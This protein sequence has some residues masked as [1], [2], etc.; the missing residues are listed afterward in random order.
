MRLARRR[1]NRN[2]LAS[3]WCL[4]LPLLAAPG[5]A[6]PPSTGTTPPN[7]IVILMDDLDAQFGSLQIMTAVQRDLAKRGTTFSQAYVPI[8]LCCPSRASILTGQYPHNHGIYTNDGALG[9]FDQ[10]RRRGHEEATVATRLQ[11][12]GYRTA[13]FGK[14]LNGYPDSADKTYIPPGWSEWVSPAADDAYGHFHYTLNDNGRLV[15]YGGRPKDYLTDVLAAKADDFVRRNAGSPYFLYLSLYAP[16]RPATPAPRHAN[17]FPA[18]KALRTASFDEAD[19]SDKPIYVRELPRLSASDLAFVDDLARKRLQSL[20]AVDELIG[21][22]VRTLRT[23]KQL[24]N[25]YLI[26]TS[27]NGF[28]LGQ[29]RLVV[30]KYTAYEEDIRVPMVVRGPGV[31]AGRTLSEPVL[32]LDLVP[33]LLQLA[34]VQ[35]PA[36]AL[37]GRSLLPLWSRDPAAVANWRKLILVEQRPFDLAETKFAIDGK[38]RHGRAGVLEPFYADEKAGLPPAF[39]ALRTATTKYIEHETGEREY[40]DL[41]TDPSELRN[42]ADSLPTATLAGL[43]AAMKQLHECAGAAC[44]EADRAAVTPWAP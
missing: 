31:P 7:F 40:Y 16:H 4:L 5:V 22:L 24:G 34:G 27:D 28:H 32:T 2:R 15:A 8:S 25:T 39:V 43:R 18:A 12:A 38:I 26:L 1:C 17:K 9:G 21:R 33:T 37:D 29:H 23:T 36:G 6:Q 41:R 10:F 42:L 30:G 3:V 44:R 11:D 19:V 14:Y 13:L 35:A 20:L